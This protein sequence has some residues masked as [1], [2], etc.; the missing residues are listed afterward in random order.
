M[1]PDRRPF[2]SLDLAAALGALLWLL[3]ASGAAAA[4]WRVDAGRSIAAVLTHK[5]GVGSGLA[6][7]HL[8]TAPAGA[9]ELD[10]DPA[11]PEKTRFTLAFRA[12]ELTID[13]PAARAAWAK[14][15]AEL[16]AH[17][18]GKLPDVGEGN[19]RKVR[20]AMLAKG[21]LDAQGHPEIRVELLAVGPRGGGGSAASARVALAWTAKIRLSVRGRSIER[22][23]ALRWEVADGRLTVE[24]L[25]EA[26]FTE[27]GIEPYSTM[28]GAIRN[29]DLFHLF[30]SLVA[31]PAQP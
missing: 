6:H 18:G 28:L 31:V 24:A 14:R 2:R 13:D 15:L 10:F 27:L 7:D 25:G 1:R 3:A 29:D 9:I 11:E 30:L 22:E 23:A 26:R 19:R 21:Q 20:E 16:G 4:S 8:V 12:E 5:A 17:P